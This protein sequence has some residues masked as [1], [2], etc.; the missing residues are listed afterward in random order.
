MNVVPG[1]ELIVAGTSLESIDRARKQNLWEESVQEVLEIN[2]ALWGMIACSA[3]K[4]VQ[5]AF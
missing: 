4:M 3:V 5:Y 1:P 2:L